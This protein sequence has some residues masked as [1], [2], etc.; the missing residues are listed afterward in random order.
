[1]DQEPLSIIWQRLAQ[2]NLRQNESL[3]AYLAKRHDENDMTLLHFAA[4][5]GK[6]DLIP[7][8][9]EAGADPNA[10][11]RIGE[12]PVDLAMAYGY[13]KTVRLLQ[14]GGGKEG[15]VLDAEQNWPRGDRSTLMAARANKFDE[16][17]EDIRAGRRGILEPAELLARDETGDNALTV[18]GREKKLEA[19]LDPKLWI[20][21]LGKLQELITLLPDDLLS[22]QETKQLMTRCRQHQ[23][24]S[25][26]RS[27]VKKDR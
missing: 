10:R 24:D 14:K 27:R 6:S 12:T 21:R 26:G 22:E 9:L 25:L 18:L 3:P 2:K 16:L 15:A 19:A 1:M 4:A 7:A 11:T 5:A 13:S 8:L 17:V 23:L 20:G